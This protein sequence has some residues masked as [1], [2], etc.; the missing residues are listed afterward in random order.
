M[1]S[2]LDASVFQA[3]GKT[4]QRAS[5]GAGVIPFNQGNTQVLELPNALLQKGITLRLTGNLVI[6]VANAQAVFSEAPWGLIKAVRI[7][8]DGR[9]QLI[10]SPARDLFRWSH[11]EWGKQTE[12]SPPLSTI[13]TRPFSATL[14]ISH[15]MMEALDP[16]ESLFDPRIFKKVTVEI[17][18]GAATDI[19]TAGGGG[20]IA[21][22][23]VQVDVLV[24][25]TS[26]GVQKILFDH[27]ITPDEQIV[28]ATT[29][30]FQF[31]VPQNGLLVGL[32]IRT[33]RDAGGGNGPVPV[34]DIVNTITLKSDTTVAHA[35]QVAWRTLQQRNVLIHQLDGGATI[36]AQ[37]PGFAYL[38]L[39]EGGMISS[40]LNT[41]ALNDLRLILNVT[42]TSGTQVVHVTYF[43]LVPR[44]SL[45][46]A[47]AA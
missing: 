4:F 1:S 47:V 3:L 40:A 16:V 27:E 29:S 6:A 5:I 33:D 23:G 45:A 32:L 44:R 10:N 26:E 37:I 35:D 39:I 8:G 25:Q 34:D 7:V 13:G 19:A 31:K 24:D 46:Q 42:N 22:S 18:W 11:L 14:H 21:L 20:T 41:N 12:L 28:T 38:A 17:T 2:A 15:E 43:W 30:L 36:G 9:R